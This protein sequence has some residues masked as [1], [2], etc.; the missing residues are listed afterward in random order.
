MASKGRATLLLAA[1]AATLVIAV[2]FAPDQSVTSAAPRL[3][4]H[5]RQPTGARGFLETAERLGWTAVRH[6]ARYLPA[7]SP[8]VV[9]AVLAPT[10]PLTGAETHELLERVRSGAALFAVVGPRTELADS[11]GIRYLGRFGRV[12]VDSGARCEPSRRARA[13]ETV[14]GAVWASAI[15]PEP[16][17]DVPV[18]RFLELGTGSGSVDALQP[19]PL[20]AAA[21]T[22]GSGRVGIVSDS[23]LLTN[24]VFRTCRL[25][26][27]VATIQ[28]L[29]FVSADSAGVFTRRTV[30]FDEF[31]HGYGRHPSVT[32]VTA[33]FMLEHPA[34]RML[35]HALL[36]G[37]V[38][39]TA[40]G[41]RPAPPAP[42]S[43]RTRRSPLEH[44]QALALA[45]SR[46]SATRTATRLLVGGLRRR[47]RPTFTGPASRAP[48]ESE[49]LNQLRKLFPVLQPE[50][51][52]V[53]RALAA[54][55]SRKEL[56]AVGRSLA[57]IERTVTGANR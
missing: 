6:E 40:A 15:E 2:L 46:I 38:L 26:P 3:T 32:R 17:G 20:A 27:G 48:A 49:F 36:A 31:H 19:A 37:V 5:S 56:A 51:D 4:T 45:Y 25:Q 53:E 21:F 11:L 43:A 44:A 14:R 7:P 1:L 23:D 18:H 47:L 24:A 54:P 50:I 16:P 42:A 33:Q 28:L 8:D 55:V 22:L 35:S 12:A 29:R 52:Q 13:A 10:I 41:A 39:L 34:G 30:V 9:Y 57:Q